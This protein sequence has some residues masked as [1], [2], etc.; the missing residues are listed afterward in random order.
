MSW[1]ARRYKQKATY[2]SVSGTDSSGDPS[3]ATPVSIKV[4]W[5]QRTVVF[6]RPNGEDSGLTTR[7][8]ADEG[9]AET[10]SLSEAEL[11]AHAHL[12]FSTGDSTGG[13]L[14]TT[15]FAPARLSSGAGDSSLRIGSAGAS[16]TV[17]LSESVGSGTAHANMQ[18]FTVVGFIMFAGAQAI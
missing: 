18:P 1:I 11:A 8:E 7:N 16:A 17:G 2:W 3:F 5:E 15:S 10:H 12:E 14:T 4:R 13:S 9:G 6:T